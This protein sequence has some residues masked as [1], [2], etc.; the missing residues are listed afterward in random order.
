MTAG[1]VEV[2]VVCQ[3]FDVLDAVA[4]G[5]ARS[6]GGCADIDGIGTVVDGLATLLKVFGG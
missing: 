6:K 4:S 3:R 2:G 1:V 5:S